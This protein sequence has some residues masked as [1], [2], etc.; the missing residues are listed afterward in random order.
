MVSPLFPRQPEW[1]KKT[2]AV[3]HKFF[4]SL[5][6]L[7][8]IA[9]EYSGIFQT[10]SP[11]AGHWLPFFSGNV[12]RQ[13]F[14]YVGNYAEKYASKSWGEDWKNLGFPVENPNFSTISTDFSTGLFHRYMPAVYAFKVNIIIIHWNRCPLIFCRIAILTIDKIFVHFWG[15]TGYFDERKTLP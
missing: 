14:R 11:N 8:K 10:F 13:K 1:Y 7:S 9:I 4:L 6:P 3:F 15:L 5:R 2:L 12:T